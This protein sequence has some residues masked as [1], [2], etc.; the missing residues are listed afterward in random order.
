MPTRD[1]TMIPFPQRNPG[2]ANITPRGQKG[3]IPFQPIQPNRLN[4]NKRVSVAEHPI[5]IRLRE[6]GLTRQ[7]LA[8]AVRRTVQTVGLYC[9]RKLMIDPDSYLGREFCRVLKTDF[10]YLIMGVRNATPTSKGSK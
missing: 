2:K 9:N 4:N 5:D 8:R 3:G 7:D 6:L 10:S 1:T